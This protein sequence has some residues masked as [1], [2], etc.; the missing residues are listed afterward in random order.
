VVL[1]ESEPASKPVLD[2]TA[3]AAAVLEG[4]APPPR[5]GKLEKN[6]RTFIG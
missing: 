1:A 5:S 4:L 6:G 3:E 2:P